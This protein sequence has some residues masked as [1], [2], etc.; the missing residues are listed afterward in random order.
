MIDISDGLLADLGHLCDASTLRGVVRQPLLPLSSAARLAIA[1]NPKLNTAVTGGGDDYE[2]LFTAP[3]DAGDAIAEAAAAS[4]VPVTLIGAIE[5]GEGVALLD[6]S[7]QPVKVEH[8]GY[9]HFS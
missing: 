3:A 8:K 5:Q 6:A 9:A 2:L 7:G 1:A 4:A